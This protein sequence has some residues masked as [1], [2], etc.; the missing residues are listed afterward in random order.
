VIT[1]D[2][3]GC[4]ETVRNGYNGFMVPV[5]DPEALAV[6]MVR[7]IDSPEL[8]A[9]MGAAS[10]KLAEEKFNI[11]HISKAMLGAMGILTACAAD[12]T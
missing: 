10:R 1:T 9:S 6:A 3:I 4:R 12:G 2:A 7:F 8:I 11:D 5:R